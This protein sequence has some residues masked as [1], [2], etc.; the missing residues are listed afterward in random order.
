LPKGIL[1]YTAFKL[2][3]NHVIDSMDCNFSIFSD[4]KTHKV[5]C[6]GSYYYAAQ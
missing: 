1:I 2:I 6:V 4:E 3:Y 5:C